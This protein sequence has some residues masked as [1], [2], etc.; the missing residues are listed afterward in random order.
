MNVLSLRARTHDGSWYA[1]TILDAPVWIG[2][3]DCIIVGRKF[4]PI[5]K[6]STIS[7]GCDL[8]IY[9]GDV[10]Q[11]ESGEWIVKYFRGMRAVNMKTREVRRLYEFKNL[12]VT[13]DATQEEMKLFGVSS[14]DVILKYEDMC[15]G[16]RN[17]VGKYRNDL[18][19][20]NSAYP[21]V[22]SRV[23]QYVTTISSRQRLFLG[24]TYRGSQV[25]MCYGAICIQNEFGAYDIIDKRYII[26]ED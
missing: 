15:F 5:I 26:K 2:G 17:V 19:V 24:D 23:R 21:V 8:G 11:D 25:I 7:I 16:V 1:F 13:R 10:L 20:S 4:S 6:L 3:D 9:V 22:V 12:W 18:V 14:L